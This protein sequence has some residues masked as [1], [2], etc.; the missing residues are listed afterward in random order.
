MPAP[1][2]AVLL[3]LCGLS[4]PAPAGLDAEAAATASRTAIGSTPPDFRLRERDG[5]ALALSAFRGKPLLVNFIYTGCHTVCPTSS[6]ALKRAVNA[7]RERFGPNQFNVASIGFD[8]P[9]D[10]PLALRDFAARQRIDDPNWAFLSPR[11]EDVPALARA[12]G[13]SY[14]ASPMG[15]DH[16]LQVSILDAQGRILTQVLGDDYPPDAIGEPLKR[17]L[18]G[19]LVE[20]DAGSFSDLWDKIRILCSVYD[21]ATGK[22]R[23]DWGLALEIA[24]GLSFLGFMLA[25]VIGEW[26]ARRALRPG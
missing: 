3:A 17:L 1:R 5:Q 26:R 23:N 2:F 19:S 12:Y 6:R 10:S 7:M 16:T 24:G 14:A 8:Q 9:Q 20:G 4:T 22:Y 18:A 25:M 15:Y 13:F 11:R 21:P